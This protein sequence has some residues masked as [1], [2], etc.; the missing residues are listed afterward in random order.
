MP[1]KQPSLTAPP[2][3]LCDWAEFKALSTPAGAFRLEALRRLWDIN[4]E[5]EDSDPQGFVER[6]EDTDDE[7]V[8]G[9]DD[10]AFI[11]SLSQEIA[12][13]RQALGETYPFQLTNAN[14][15]EVVGPPTEGGYVYLFCLLLTYTNAKEILDGTWVPA[16]DNAVRDLFQVGSTLAAAGEVT[17]CAVSFGWPRPNGNPPFLRRLQEVYGMFGEGEVVQ[18]PRKGV[19]PAP[20]DEE[21]DVIAWR[22]RP[23]RAAGAAFYMLGQVASGDNWMGK[24]LEGAPIRNFHRNWFTQDPVT[25]PRGYIFIPHAVPP[26]DIQ[27]TRRERLN[28]ITARYG[29]IIDRM[30]LPRLSEEGL[31]LAERHHENGL[32]IERVNEFA[33]IGHWV[34]A[35]LT[36]LHKAALT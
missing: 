27:G 23:D 28:A 26:V 33:G 36:A 12:D 13:R 9:G 34:N 5:R 30:R 20:K 32:H 16:V 19:S 7:G 4:R 18:R 35:Q 15:L 8:Q 25:V 31:R 3:L 17:G 2:Y 29:T 14:R 11:D 21:I 6:E 24:P 10:E 1:I 22:P